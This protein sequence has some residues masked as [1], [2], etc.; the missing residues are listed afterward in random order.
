MNTETT[1]TETRQVGEPTSEPSNNTTPKPAINEDGNYQY[2]LCRHIKTNGRRCQAPSLTTAVY[3]YFHDRLHRRHKKFRFG[4]D[5]NVRL[6]PGQEIE[7]NALEDRESI[8]MAI[9]IV[10][11]S[12]ATGYIDP[13]RARILLYG[14]QMASYNMRYLDN[15][16]RPE[17]CVTE[18][19]ATPGFLD[20][21]EPEIA[22]I[23]PFGHFNP[24]QSMIEDWEDDER[25]EKL[26]EEWQ[27]NKEAQED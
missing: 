9:S 16:P 13:R 6:C 25:I 7:L 11:N 10:T 8:Q 15:M 4:E 27:E 18:A 2:H 5:P 3:C 21:A 24:V 26:I 23:E 20:I 17:E 22:E 12:L 1:T 14:L 19:E